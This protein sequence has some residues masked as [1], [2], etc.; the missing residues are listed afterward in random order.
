MSFT[1]TKNISQSIASILSLKISGVVMA[2]H[3][4]IYLP[5]HQ[6]FIRWAAARSGPTHFQIFPARPGS[7]IC[8]NSRS[9]PAQPMTLAARPMGP[10]LY[11]GWPTQNHWL[12]RVFDGPDHGPA[13]VLSCTK[14]VTHIICAS[15]CVVVLCVFDFFSFGSHGP[16]VSGP[17]ITHDNF[18]PPTTQSDRFR[19]GW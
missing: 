13:D 3:P 14:R 5:A 16:A 12:A 9:G 8:R 19:S 11:T 2:R 17:R 10:G 7:S 1:T 4:L 6:I 15:V 18:P